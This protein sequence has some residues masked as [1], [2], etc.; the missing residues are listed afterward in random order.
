MRNLLKKVLQQ[1]E[2]VNR[3]RE[4]GGRG[5]GNPPRFWRDGVPASQL[6]HKRDWKQV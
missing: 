3:K 1:K 6:G 5:K 2:G 4:K